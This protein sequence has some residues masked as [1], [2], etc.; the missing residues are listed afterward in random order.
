MRRQGNLT[1]RGRR[2]VGGRVLVVLAAMGL[3]GLAVAP[4]VAA[5]RPEADG[6]S[7]ER[8]RRV[9]EFVEW[10]VAAGSFSGAVTLVARHGR[11]AHLEARGL[12]DLESKR[13]M[14]TDAIFRI[15]SMTKPVVAVSILMLVEEGKVK[16]GEPA[17]RFIPALK[18]LQVAIPQGGRSTRVGRIRL[19]FQKT[20]IRL[21]VQCPSVLTEGHLHAS[22]ITIRPVTLSPG[23]RLGAYDIIALLGTGGMGEVYRATDTN[24]K[25]QVALKVLPPAV[26]ADADRL[27]R[28]Q[29]EAEVL[30]AL[31]HPHIAQIYGIERR[32]ASAN[33]EAAGVT[34]LVM[35]L[36]E[37]EDLS[38]RIARGHIPL[39]EALPIAR[40]IA[41]A[42]E[43]AHEQGIIHRDLKPANIKVRD[44]GTV[45]VLDF[46]LAKAMETGA[47]TRESGTA[48]T[49]AHSPTITTPAMTHAGMI[50]G[51]AAYMAPEQAK[52]RAVDKRADIWAFGCVLYEMLTGRRAFPGEDITETL[53][54]VVMRE[55][56]WSRL[57]ASTPPSIRRLLARCL[58][59]DRQRRLRDIGDAYHELSGEPAADADGAARA[60]AR[61]PWMAAAVAVTAALGLAVP[62]LSHW[63]EAA[64][65]ARS[66]RLTIDAPANSVR[67][68]SPEI[69]PDG[70]TVAFG[71]IASGSAGPQ[72]WLRR[73][74]EPMPRLTAT[75][76]NP[77]GAPFWSPDGSAVAIPSGESLL[78][79]DL[80]T[81][82]TRPL[83]DIRTTL[84]GISQFSGTW[85]PQ[86]VI[87][88]GLGST[89]LRV[90]ENGGDV[91]PVPFEG[92]R[93]GTE[94]RFPVFLP[95]GRRFFFLS[96]EPGGEPHISVASVDGGP[97]TRLFAA[98]S[99][100]V[101]TEPA[102]GRGHVLYVRDGNLFALPFDPGTLTATGPAYVVAAGVPLYT[103]EFVG[104]GRGAFSV[105]PDGVIVYISQAEDVLQ[106]LTW[107][108]RQGREIGTVG[109][110]ALYFGPRLSPDGR[111]IAVARLDRRTRLGDI[112]VVN[113]SGGSERLTFDPANDLQPVWSPDGAFIIWG[114]QRNG[115]SQLL[116]KRADGAGAEV[117]LHES[118]HPLAPDDVSPDG[119]IVVFRESHPVTKNDLWTVPL[120]GSEPARPLL[121]TDADEPR[122]RF[123]PDGRLIG[124]ISDN[125]AYVQPFPEMSSKWQVSAD[126]GNVPQWRRDGREL[127]FSAGRLDG[128]GL[129]RATQLVDG[130]SD[131][132]LVAR[133]VLGTNPLRLGEPVALFTPPVTPRGSFFHASAD[134]QRFL[135]APERFTAETLRYHVAIGWMKP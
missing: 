13:P 41:E 76:L 108:D 6:F 21:P 105:S 129:Q 8:L 63:R 91:R 49:L 73:L 115:K 130:S 126:R 48:Q 29:R 133:A 55:P 20:L 122:A 57:P 131:S 113:E 78:H 30:A 94:T 70:R 134:G 120:D 23:T 87:L 44:D 114:S 15:M 100:A 47:A 38:R 99:Q 111:R 107:I 53:A 17:S 68:L 75:P 45:K 132:S 1:H 90:S 16:L 116:R 127:Y 83:A 7:P 33:G 77:T 54:A 93:A 27:A 34:A 104:T 52:G 119:R 110:P 96:R 56:D 42:L 112:Y 4:P 123:S 86:G 98:E 65:P 82:G 64:P 124:Y 69:A 3:A 9:G 14:R 35:E 118:E 84:V 103:A 25:R 61:L 135:F 24:L 106:R 31:N 60:P 62:A 5:Q 80:A 81:G 22:R 121:N 36:V 67:L 10:R 85:S 89:I 128:R 18:G 101:Y 125:R 32:V 102:P 58:S 79:V 71:S 28:F 51:T 26:A 97:V 12:A 46:G 40:Q 43:A 92:L 74:D 19:G 11:I 88:Y 109:E 37:G 66:L 50:L 72:L 2:I 117:L 39:D 95:D 59:K